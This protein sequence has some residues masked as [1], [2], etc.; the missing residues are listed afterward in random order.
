M[1]TIPAAKRTLIKIRDS[2]EYDHTTTEFVQGLLE[3]DKILE[4]CYNGLQRLKKP[5][6]RNESEHTL[7]NMLEECCCAQWRARI[8]D[9]GDY[10]PDCVEHK[11]MVGTNRGEIIGIVGPKSRRE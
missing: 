2:I 3:L 8:R 5:Q 4:M 6:S 7:A 9:S 10:C 1:G 11:S